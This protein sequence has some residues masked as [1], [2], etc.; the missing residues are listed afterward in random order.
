MRALILLAN[1]AV[2]AVAIFLGSWTG[3]LVAAFLCF[4][5]IAAFFVFSTEKT[6]ALESKGLRRSMGRSTTFLGGLFESNRR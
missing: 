1:I 5:L 6:E 3:L 2:I 4:V